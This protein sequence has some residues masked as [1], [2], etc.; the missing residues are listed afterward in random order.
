MLS[1]QQAALG[2]GDLGFSALIVFEE[3]NKT[4]YT[5]KV[6]VFKEVSLKWN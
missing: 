6:Y 4:N 1:R 5:Y 2:V 3:C